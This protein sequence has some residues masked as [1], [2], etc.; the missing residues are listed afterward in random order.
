MIRLLI[1]EQLLQV[2]R[3]A[4]LETE[5][6]GSVCNDHPCDL[7]G[8][9]ALCG[10]RKAQHIPASSLAPSISRAKR[11]TKI[12]YPNSATI[13]WMQNAPERY[14]MLEIRENIGNSPEL[15]NLDRRTL[16]LLLAA[17]SGHG[18]FADYHRRF[19][20]PDALLTCSCGREKSPDHF[21]FCRLGCSRSGLHGGP[22]NPNA[23]IPWALS[24]PEGAIAFR[25]WVHKTKFFEEIHCWS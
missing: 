21:F 20:H 5:L 25:K 6:S 2:Y 14:R 7:L 24:F 9:Q 1:M 22:R 11:D 17:R 13:Y 15:R 18:D 23:G 3:R 19:Q 4:W 16:G 10:L 12:R 8:S